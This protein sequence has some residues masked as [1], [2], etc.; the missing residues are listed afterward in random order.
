MKAQE[1]AKPQ[2]RTTDKGGTLWTIGTILLGVLVYL[3]KNIAVVTE[4][5]ASMGIPDATISV[6]AGLI[7]LGGLIYAGVTQ[8]LA[9]VLLCMFVG[10]G[11]AEA[12]EAQDVFAYNQT[13]IGTEIGVLNIGPDSVAYW[14]R[15]N[16]D[17]VH[18][19]ISR[20][21]LAHLPRS[22]E[23]QWHADDLALI[24][25]Y[26][27]QE[28]LLPVSIPAHA[29]PMVSDMA[30]SLATVA[31]QFELQNDTLLGLV[32]SITVALDEEIAENAAKDESIA[33]LQAD[34]AAFA[35]TVATLRRELEEA[36]QPDGELLARIEELNTVVN[37]AMQR[38]SEALERRRNQ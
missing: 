22:G 28:G 29:D 4:T 9:V 13:D 30:D 21:I 32:D 16:E 14:F 15:H 2:N 17:S 6:V 27:E 3:S 26:A 19:V 1:A 18:T 37:H 8:Q 20:D 31:Y 24:M 11:T 23:Y 34:T 5:L 38:I 7:T 33:A 25:D 35:D 12:A 36:G 10:F